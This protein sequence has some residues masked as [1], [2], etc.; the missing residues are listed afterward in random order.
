MTDATRGWALIA[1][2]AILGGGLVGSA[3][4]AA[5]G[6]E[7]F[8][9]ADR[10]VVVKG[11][12][13]RDVSADLAIWPLR[14]VAASDAL[15]AGQAEI[16]AARAKIEQFLTARGFSA[17]EMGVERLEV[18]DTAANPYQSNQAPARFILGQTLTLRSD[19]VAAV[20]DAISHSGELVAQGVVLSP[21]AGAPQFR[22]T[23]LNAIKPELIAEAT[24]EARRAAEQFARDSGSA[25][26]VIRDANQGVIQILPR[27]R[28]DAYAETQ[29]VEKRVRV[30]TTVT[31]GL[32]D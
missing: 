5:Q 14:L 2:A 18:T 26:G 29:S 21:D 8:R 31:Y 20:V 32:Q 23:G 25:V 1:A 4:I 22:F 11:S 24:A 30:V 19:K 27:D 13:E 17:E 12:A 3:Y 9:M 16:T 15:D 10:V 6:L 28:D 7:R